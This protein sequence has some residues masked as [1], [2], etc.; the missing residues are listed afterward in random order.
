MPTWKDYLRKIYYNPIHP[1]AFSCPDK[2]YKIVKKEGR[3]T[4]GKYRIQKWLQDQDA[5]SLQKPV[6]YKIKRNSH[7]CWYR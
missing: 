2:L 4:I 3:H 7:C 5:Y 6:K 1:A